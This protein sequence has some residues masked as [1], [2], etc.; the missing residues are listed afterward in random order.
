MQIARVF[1]RRTTATPSCPRLQRRFFGRC[2][3]DPPPPPPPPL[4][5]AALLPRAMSLLRGG[6]GI[7]QSI[8]EQNAKR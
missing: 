4:P 6:V 5:V 3:D 7:Y 1:P 2:F 8:G